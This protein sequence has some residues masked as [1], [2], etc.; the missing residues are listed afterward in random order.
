MKTILFKTAA[1][2]AAAASLCLLSGCRESYTV[3]IRN[4]CE[5]A[6]S[7]VNIYPE[8]KSNLSKNYLE[9]ELP[10]GIETEVELDAFDE[11]DIALGFDLIVVNAED[12]SEGTFSML[13]FGDGDKLTFYMDDWGLAVGVNMTDEEVAEEIETEHENFLEYIEELEDEYADSEETTQE[14][15][16]AE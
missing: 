2:T 3:T 8:G 9:N 15:T 5:V 4:L 13:Q 14:T 6:I 12:N 10:S 7:E 1:L 11:E 16:E